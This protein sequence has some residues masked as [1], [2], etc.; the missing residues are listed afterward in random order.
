MRLESLLWFDADELEGDIDIVFFAVPRVFLFSDFHKV[1]KDG[2]LVNATQFPEF[3][4][5]PSKIVF[6][7]LAGHSRF[8][9]ISVRLELCLIGSLPLL[10]FALSPGITASTR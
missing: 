4:T 3:D 8:E 7:V 6:H 1:G 2:L 5:L 9:D 10:L